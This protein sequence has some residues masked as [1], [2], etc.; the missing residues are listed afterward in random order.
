MKRRTWLAGA[1]ALALSTFFLAGH[2]ATSL[3]HRMRRAPRDLLRRLRA[4]TRPFDPDHVTRGTDL[5]G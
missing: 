3:A 1:A 4:R 5:A 2:G